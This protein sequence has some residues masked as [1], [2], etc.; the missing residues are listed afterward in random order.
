MI[1]F[2]IEATGSPLAAR[3]NPIIY[4]ALILGAIAIAILGGLALLY[5]LNKAKQKSPEWI[6]AQKNRP[7]KRSDIVEFSE[8][9][10][11]NS[12]EEN[13]LWRFCHRTKPNNILYTF[14][15]IGYLD[16]FFRQ[17]YDELRLDNNQ[18]EMNTFF[19]V[20]FKIE[21]IL[22]SLCNVTTTR[23]LAKDWK[24]T[25]IFPDGTKAHYSV[26]ENTKDYLAI[27]ITKEVFESEDKPQNMDKVA[28]SFK[29][30]QGMKY[31]FVSRLMRYEQTNEGYIML[32]SHSNDLIA[33]VARSFKR[34]NVSEK[35]KIASVKVT[36]N[37]KGE[38]TLVADEKKFDCAITNI[39]GGGCCVCTTL[40]VKEGQNIYVE[41]NFPDGPDFAF[42][43]IVKTR[44]ART[45]GLYNL[46][47]RFTNITLEAQNKILAKVYRY[48]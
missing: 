11:L 26:Y 30:E 12:T 1:L 34:I 13:C 6:E 35:C 44:K 37:K 9:Y 17:Y 41:L 38:K 14:K 8:K 23:V 7:T 21:R 42:G 25:E 46:H 33:K 36:T 5:N 43:T 19:S 15:E 18:K 39:S 45:A 3:M 10:K 2:L 28:F 48:N 16:P 20:M 31:A 4:V 22:A 40:P 32:V 27:N 24:I 29:T 47:V